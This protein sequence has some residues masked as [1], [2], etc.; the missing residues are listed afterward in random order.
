MKFLLMVCWDTD[1]MNAQTEPDP[2][3]PR[4]DEGFWWVDDLRAELG[5]WAGVRD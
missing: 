5:E 4:E 2:S 1:R 3:E